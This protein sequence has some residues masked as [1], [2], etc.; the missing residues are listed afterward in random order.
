[1]IGYFAKYVF[2]MMAGLEFTP[3]ASATTKGIYTYLVRIQN[4]RFHFPFDEIYQRLLFY[5]L[6]RSVSV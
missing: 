4:F 5:T 3:A 2:P 6:G 1:M